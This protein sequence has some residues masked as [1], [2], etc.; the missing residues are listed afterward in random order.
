MMFG[1]YQ[2]HN[3]NLENSKHQKINLMTGINVYFSITL[4]INELNFLVKRHRLAHWIR[5][6]IGYKNLPFYI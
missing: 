6:L 4:L 3:K 5:N 2:L 1:H